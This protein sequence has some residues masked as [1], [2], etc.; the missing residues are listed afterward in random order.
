MKRDLKL[1]F[2]GTGTI[3]PD[4]ERSCSATILETPKGNIL[5]DIGAGTLR[6]MAVEGIDIHS[7]KYIFITHFH[8][9]HIGDLIPFL[10]ALRNFRKEAEEGILRIWGPVGLHRFVQGMERAYGKWVQFSGDEVKFYELKRR[11]LD[12]PGFRLIWSK[13]THTQESVGFRFEIDKRV[14][15]FSGDTGYCQEL[16]RL[17][18]D[19][20]VAV[21][22]CSHADK[23]AVKGHLSPSLTAKIAETATAKKIIL[24]HFYPDALENNPVEIARKYY[25]GEIIMANDSDTFTIPA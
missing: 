7:I 3:Y 25:R 13:V 5:I 21:I 14:I 8:P 16:I 15:V 17:S 23:F 20:D 2:L 1:R 22:E 10:F 24:N 18:K 12:F 4:P 9:D 19:A 6:R 11:L